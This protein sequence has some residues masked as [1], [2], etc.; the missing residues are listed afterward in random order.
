MILDS[1]MSQNKYS[2]LIKIMIFNFWK[3]LQN[4]DFE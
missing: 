3:S 2:D 4:S 1:L